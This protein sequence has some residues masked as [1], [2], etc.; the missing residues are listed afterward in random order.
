MHFDGWK[1]FYQIRKATP[2]EYHHYPHIQLT[3]S[4]P[5][6]PQRRRYSRRVHKAV[7]VSLDEWRARLGYPT[8]EVTNTTIKST[9]QMVKSLEAETREYMRDHYKTRSLATRPRRLSDRMYSDTFFSSLPSIRGFKCFQMFAFKQSKFDK[10]HLMRKES[11]N[12]EKYLDVIRHIGAPDF[13]V[14]D[15]AKSM[16]GSKWS[17]TNR[18]YCIGQGTSEPHHQTQNYTE[19]R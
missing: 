2:E 18:Y 14:T 1:C 19:G 5:Y 3:S 12:H 9:T 10:I 13:V 11:Q 7:D 16:T 17:N 8:L 6:E 4:S 15:N